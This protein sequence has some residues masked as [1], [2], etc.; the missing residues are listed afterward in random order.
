[1]RGASAAP[2]ASP[3]VSP[4]VAYLSDRMSVTVS[5]PSSMPVPQ[6]TKVR[7]DGGPPRCLGCYYVLAGLGSGVCPE[8]GTKVFRIGKS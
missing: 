2:T 1:M 4:I 7:P 8:C 6:P 5:D 3:V